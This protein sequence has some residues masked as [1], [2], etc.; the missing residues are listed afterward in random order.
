MSATYSVVF[1]A[2][3]RIFI[4]YIGSSQIP[5]S[6]PTGLR[7]LISILNSR[8]TALKVNKLVAC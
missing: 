8:P 4:M 7:K 5:C 1:T 3:H 2:K 6:P